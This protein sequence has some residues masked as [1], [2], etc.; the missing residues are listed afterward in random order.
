MHSPESGTT[1][2][3]QVC[4]K[5]GTA[6]QLR[7]QAGYKSTAAGYQ[8]IQKIVG[9]YQILELEHVLLAKSICCFFQIV[10]LLFKTDPSCPLCWTWSLERNWL[11]QLRAKCCRLQGC[12]QHNIYVWHLVQGTEVLLLYP[13]C[14]FT[15]R[16]CPSAAEVFKKFKFHL[17]S[18]Y[19]VEGSFFLFVMGFLRDWKVCLKQN[20]SSLPTRLLNPGFGIKPSI[21]LEKLHLFAHHSG[22]NLQ[23]PSGSRLQELGLGSG[24]QRVRTPVLLSFPCS[25]PSCTGRARPGCAA[26]PAPVTATWC[27]RVALACPQQLSPARCLLRLTEIAQIYV[28]SYENKNFCKN[29]PDIRK[30]P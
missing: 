21:P 19:D 10:Q 16:G 26:V 24:Q 28:S 5:D 13:L 22:C 3:P 6:A 23:C 17:S 8:N 1:A 2:L 20:L 29:I 12:L 14:S 4:P 11:T 30:E 25:P 27:P 15:V 18:E 9:E 7:Q